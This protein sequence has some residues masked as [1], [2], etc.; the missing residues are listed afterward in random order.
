VCLAVFTFSIAGIHAS[1]KSVESNNGT[2]E[3]KEPLPTINTVTTT[4]EDQNPIQKNILETKAVD[5]PD[6]LKSIPNTQTMPQKALPTKQAQENKEPVMVMASIDT[7]SMNKILKPVDSGSVQSYDKPALLTQNETMEDPNLNSTTV[8]ANVVQNNMPKDAANDS[9]KKDIDTAIAE[10]SRQIELNDSDAGLYVLRGN[11]YMDK[12]DYEQAVNDFTKAIE[13]NPDEVA[14]YNNRG[15][16]YANMWEECNYNIRRQAYANIAKYNNPVEFQQAIKDD[17]QADKYPFKQFMKDRKQADRDFFNQAINDYKKAIKK[18]PENIYAYINRGNAYYAK[19]QYRKAISDYTR[20]IKIDPQFALPYINRGNAYYADSSFSDAI[21]DFSKAL[22]LDVK[23]AGIYL[24][25]GNAYYNKSEYRQAINDY[26][27]ALET[28]PYFINAYKNRGM[29]YEGM[30]ELDKAILDYSKAIAIISE[31]PDAFINPKNFSKERKGFD[32][33]I[34]YNYYRQNSIYDNSFWN[35]YK[36]TEIYSSMNPVRWNSYVDYWRYNPEIYTVMIAD[37]LSNYMDIEPLE[38]YINRGLAY[39][40]KNQLDKAISDLSRVIEIIP[41]H[42]LAYLYRSEVYRKMGNEVEYK[43]DLDIAKKYGYKSK[44]PAETLSV[45]NYW[46]G[47]PMDDYQRM[48]AKHIESPYEPYPY[49]PSSVDI[50]NMIRAQQNN[51][52][53]K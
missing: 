3:L 40:K 13:I 26:S 18:D 7:N 16:A 30:D 52:G 47:N 35:N 44:L 39:E 20:A 5:E 6:K 38:S 37:S 23:E 12:Q 19:Q 42:A 22:E 14:A 29:A 50:D 46:W 48:K 1:I 17:K 15:Q 10:L 24:L 49:T 8:P 28:N 51:S 31:S 9:K 41:N 27:K 21:K 25:R 11:L 4:K 34:I 33:V 53:R 45:R 32:A 43:N 36:L 2:K